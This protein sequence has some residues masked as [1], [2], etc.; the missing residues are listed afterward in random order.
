[1]PRSRRGR[2]SLSPSRMSWTSLP[3]VSS[4]ATSGEDDQHVALVDGLALLAA[5]LGDRAVVLG[6]DRDL[7]LHRLEDHQRVALVDLVT[8]RDLDLPDVA[9]DVGLDVH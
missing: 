8:D 2:S 3:P 9:G 7:H 1:M 4:S 6:L 5:D